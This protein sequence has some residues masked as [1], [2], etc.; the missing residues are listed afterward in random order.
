MNEKTENFL[1]EY[2]DGT[3]NEQQRQEAARLLAESAEAQAFFDEL[4]QTFVGLAELDDVPMRRDLS[5][6]IMTQIEAERVSRWANWWLIGQ[7]VGITI[8]LVFAWPIL[9]LLLAEAGGIL[10]ISAN[11][12]LFD[13]IPQFWQQ[14]GSGVTAVFTTSTLSLPTFGLTPIQLTWLLGTAFVVWL[15]SNG[16]LLP[17]DSE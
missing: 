17:F 10:E 14:L 5:S 2:L 12:Q 7:I 9:K 4:Q 6:S 3:L 11:L 13:A 16:L 15:L 1:N 8:L